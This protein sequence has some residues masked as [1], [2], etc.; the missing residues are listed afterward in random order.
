MLRGSSDKVVETT[1][2]DSDHAIPHRKGFVT[3]PRKTTRG[4]PSEEETAMQV[5]SR[6]AKHGALGR[7]LAYYPQ[8]GTK[9]VLVRAIVRGLTALGGGG[10]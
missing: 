1:L 3:P 7:A 2:L 9:C 6:E 5:I 8:G 10:D 4:R